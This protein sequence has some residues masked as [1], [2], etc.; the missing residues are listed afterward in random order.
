MLSQCFTVSA[1]NASVAR[2]RE[3]NHCLFPFQ[4]VSYYFFPH[5]FFLAP[6]Q[7]CARPE[8][9]VASRARATATTQIPSEAIAR[10]SLFTNTSFE[11]DN[12]VLSAAWPN[13]WPSSRNIPPPPLHSSRRLLIII[14][15]LCN[16]YSKRIIF[17]VDVTHL[18][19]FLF[20]NRGRK[21]KDE[22]NIVPTQPCA[23]SGQTG[24]QGPLFIPFPILKHKVSL[25]SKWL[26]QIYFWILIP[27][28]KW[29]ILIS[30]KSR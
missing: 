9:G 20:R 23:G 27:L 25:L 1:W 3:A 26:R 24:V 11:D 14:I 19:W 10:A 18:E 17:L 29:M 30:T 21:N 2:G 13:T 6:F 4:S 8:C 5:H 15:I 7:V 22:K 16:Q 12:P 28:Y